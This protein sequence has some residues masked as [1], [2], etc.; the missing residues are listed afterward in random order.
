MTGEVSPS[1]RDDGLV[2]PDELRVS[3]D[4]RDRVVELLRV[5][6]GDGRLTA[7]ELDERLETALTART[8][9]ELAA[10]SRDLPAAPEV[11][12]PKDLVHIVCDHGTV[13]RVG[14]WAVPQRMEIQITNGSVTLDFTEAVL[15]YPSLRISVTANAGS[16]RIVTKPGV[17]VDVDDV[18]LHAATAHVHDPQSA[19][20]LLRIRVAGEIWASTITARPPRRSFFQWLLRR[21]APYAL[22]R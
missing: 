22:T 3:H 20:P 12:P 15:T 5:A 6:A 1:G 18:N 11:D 17:V 13:R 7:E 2:S 14:R 8:Y 21:P 4:D 19:E 10:L 9:G 16:L